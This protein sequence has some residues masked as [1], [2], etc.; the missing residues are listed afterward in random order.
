MYFVSDIGTHQWLM[1]E[2]ELKYWQKGVEILA[3]KRLLEKNC[4]DENIA[5]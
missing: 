2:K 1:Y 4:F 5:H 3:E